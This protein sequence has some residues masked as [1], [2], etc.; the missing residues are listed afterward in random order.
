MSHRSPLGND[1][2]A[3]ELFLESVCNETASLQGDYPE[4]DPDYHGTEDVYNRVVDQ[5]QQFK[6]LAGEH[7][8]FIVYGE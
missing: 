1:R 2:V 7:F 6:E 4:F 5:A 8:D 3:A